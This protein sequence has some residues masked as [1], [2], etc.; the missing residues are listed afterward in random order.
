MISLA[1][2]REILGDA[3]GQLSDPELERLRQEL[4]G[5]ADIA[6]KLFLRNRTNTHPAKEPGGSEV[7]QR[8]KNLR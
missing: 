7:G 2:C 5:L 1:E 6:V 8:A 4:Y 3:G